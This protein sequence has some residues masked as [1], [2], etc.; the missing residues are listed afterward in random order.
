MLLPAFPL[1]AGSDVADSGAATGGAAD[2]TIRPADL[3]HEGVSI[4]VVSEMLDG[5]LEGFR[6]IGFSVHGPIVTDIG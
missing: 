6:G 2:L 5:F 3:S 4:A 1:T